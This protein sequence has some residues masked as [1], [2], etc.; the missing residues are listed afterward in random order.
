M[1]DRAIMSMSGGREGGRR[2]GAGRA[3]AVIAA[4]V[5]AGAVA[6]FAVLLGMGRSEDAG[7]ADSTPPTTASTPTSQPQRLAQADLPP[8]LPA[9]PT[10]N[11]D[12]EHVNLI[13]G[14]L[15]ALHQGDITGNYTVVRDLA[16]PSFRERNSAADLSRIFLPIRQA[17][18]DLSVA[19]V[20]DLKFAQAPTIDQQNLLKATGTFD[21][22]P[23]PVRFEVM[24]QSVGGR[25]RLVG[26]SV[27]PVQ[28]PE[29]PAR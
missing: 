17:R 4:G 26:V 14:T 19:A 8:T 12:P 5:A 25:W 9:P 22:K 18:I 13:R 20:Q 27:A 21:S 6:V 29:T 1:T 16:A 10:G 28:Q 15:I 11:I 2:R 24:Y 3:F 7:H 23:S